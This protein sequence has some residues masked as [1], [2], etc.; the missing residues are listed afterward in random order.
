MTRRVG[1]FGGFDR[2]SCMSCH[3]PLDLPYGAEPT[4]G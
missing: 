3:G 1:L 4:D 2:L